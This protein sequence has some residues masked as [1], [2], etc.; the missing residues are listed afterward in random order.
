MANHPAIHKFRYTVASAH[1]LE[2]IEK[3]HLVLHR[4]AL[5]AGHHSLHAPHGDDLAVLATATVGH[6]HNEDGSI[7]IGP[8]ETADDGTHLLLVVAEPLAARML[9]DGIEAKLQDD[10]VV[11]VE[12]VHLTERLLWNLGERHSCTS[13]HREVIHRY[14]LMRFE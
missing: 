6:A 14:S 7:R 2:E 13:A 4:N 5:L 9:I 8:L 11:R 12:A 3:G 10:E 1:H